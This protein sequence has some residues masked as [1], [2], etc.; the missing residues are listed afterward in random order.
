MNSDQT[1]AAFE[2]DLMQLLAWGQ[3]YFLEAGNIQYIVIAY[4]IQFV[5]LRKP[6]HRQNPPLLSLFG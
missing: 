1:A 3:F 4:S 2:H 5:S 6:S